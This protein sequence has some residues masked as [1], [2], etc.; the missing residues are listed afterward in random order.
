MINS[1]EILIVEDELLIAKN[2]AKKLTKFGY[3][4]A[5][6]VS[7]GRAAIDFVTHNS[8]DLVLMD[9]AIKGDLDGID[10]ASEIKSIADV[11]IIFMTAY[12]NDETL[13]RA[14]ETGCYGYLIKPYKERELQATVKMVLNKHLEQSTIRKVMQ[15]SIEEYSAEYDD[16]YQDNLTG[17][18]NKLFL[19]DLFEYL[20]S[21][22]NNQYGVELESEPKPKQSSIGI[23]NISLD[24]LTKISNLMNKAEAD[25]LVKE[26]AKRLTQ[27]VDNLDAHGSTVYL[28]KDR[29]VVLL[30]IEERAVAHKYGSML[31]NALK[32]DFKAGDRQIY[33]TP[34]IGIALSPRDGSDITEL[35]E[36]SDKAIEYARSKGGNRC[37]EFTFALNIKQ[38]RIADN[39]WLESEL[40]NALERQEFELYYQPRLELKTNSILGCEALIRWHHRKMGRIDADKFIPTA[41]DV[42]L[43][44]PIGEWV[45]TTAC[46][47]MQAWLDAGIDIQQISVN[48]SGAQ[49]QQSDLFHQITQI[50]FKTSL[51]PQF[52]ELELTE[53]ILVEEIKTNVQKLNL[54]KKLGVKISLDDFGTG[55]ASLGY[56]QQFPFDILKIDRCFV[57]DIHQ[58]QINAVITQ[59]IIKMAHQ[60]GLKVIAEGVENSSELEFLNQAQCDGIQGFVF[61]RPLPAAEFKRLVLEHP[62]PVNR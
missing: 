32:E 21:I 50:L 27:C 28:Q 18:P 35:L 5:K 58:N 24:R 57:R 48:L 14:A 7:T 22:I 52:L 40:H 29:F 4:V 53:G 8:P 43:M 61:S 15:S 34:T 12:A 59:S 33:L 6:I 49:F 46:R 31:L 2:T 60:L 26:I 11:P 23:Y 1:T 56:L 44:K 20:S 13:D 36:R 17:L 37:Q 10:T 3:N 25:L 55:Y 45:L 51:E 42:G 16:I 19:R 41:E 39:L 62:R 30:A 47:Q 9:I 38:N 54:L